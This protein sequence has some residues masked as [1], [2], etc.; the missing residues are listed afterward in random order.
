LAEVDTAARD[1]KPADLSPAE[2]ALGRGAANPQAIPWRGWKQALRRAGAQMISDRISLSAAGCAFYATLALFPAITMLIF[3]YGLLFDPQTVE[4]QLQVLQQ[5][6]PDSAYQ[7]IDARI[8]QLV[9]KPQGSLTLG[10]VISVLFTLWSAATGTKSILSALNMAYNETERRSFLRFQFVSLTMTMAAML[11]AVLAIAIL[12]FLPAVFGFIGLSAQSKGLI[13]VAS[14]ALLMLFVLISLS[15][16]Y[17]FGPCRRQARWAW[18]TPG[19]LLATLLWVVAS[20]LLSFYISD[21]ASYD[22]TYGPLGAVAGVMMWFY[23]TVVVVLAGAELNAELEM[24]T[25]RDSTEGG[26]R[27]MGKRGAFVADHVAD[28]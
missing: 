4:P 7:L 8:H 18:V 11:G 2:T 16:L 13:R 27:P 5:L 6:L 23:V 10:L 25:L 20:A 9:A 1:H 15:M 28:S 26:P 12:V 24:Q 22:T 21:V 17:R 14:L 19:S 3:L